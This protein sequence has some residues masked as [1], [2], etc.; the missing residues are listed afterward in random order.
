MSCEASGLPWHILEVR[1]GDD[2]QVRA[3]KF[4]SFTPDGYQAR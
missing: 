1:K 2:E 3:G 4:V